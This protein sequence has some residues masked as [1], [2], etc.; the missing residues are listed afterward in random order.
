VSF[1]DSSFVDLDAPRIFWINGLAGTGKTTI[2]YTVAKRCDDSEIFRLGASFFCSRDDV[3]SS[4]PKFV[5]T[6][7]ADQ[8][9]QFYPPFQEQLTRAHVANPGL[10]YS[11]VSNQLEKL[12]VK[13]LRAVR[14][15]F[16]AC[17]LVLDAVDECKDENATS[18]ILSSLSR[19]IGMLTPLK[20]LVTSR[21][22][23]KITGGF[24]LA[25]LRSATQCLNLHEVKLDVVEQ[26]IENY[27]TVC[28]RDVQEQYQLDDDWPLTKDLHALARLASGLFIF[29]A[30]AVNF[31]QVNWRFC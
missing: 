24:R 6:T 19:H 25:S 7:I 14:D 10:K 26:D 31:I 1:A 21:P 5:F 11:S 9:G 2:A 15:N 22:E 4:N 3:D 16:P 27:L 12:I 23:P 30:T 29:A 28:L 20:F 13:P 18:I 17:V 8:L